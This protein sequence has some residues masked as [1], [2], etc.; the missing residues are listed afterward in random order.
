MADRKNTDTLRPEG[1][2]PRALDA[3]L[4]KLLG[5]F[6]CVEITG[7][8]WCG[9]TWT[10]L[11]HA[12]SVDR[13]DD[14]AALSAAMMDA[15]LVL[16]GKAPH[17]I[18]EW[19]EVP[20]IWDAV[21]RRVDEQGNSKGLFVL[22]GSSKP[23]SDAIRHSGTGRIARIHMRSMSLFETGDSNGSVSLSSI[24]DGD[25]EPR[26]RKT[27]MSEIARWCCRGG[28]PS[29]LGMEDDFALE[30]P[31]EY[32]KSV[33]DVSVRSLNK[34][35]VVAQKLMMALSLNLTQSVT[36][37]VLARDV[38]F[39]DE[40]AMPSVPTIEAYLDLL[41]S[42][43]LL[44]DLTGWEP[45]LISKQRVRTRP[46]RFFVDPSIPAAL[47][48]ATPATLL[49]DMQTLGKLFES[50]CIRDLRVYLSVLPGIGNQINYYLDDKGLEV[51]AVIQMGDGRWGAFEIKLSDAKIDEAAACL[52]RFAGKI[53]A[54]KAARVKAPEFLAVL[55]GKG[56]IAYKRNDGVLVIPIATLAP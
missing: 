33:L 46:K 4:E 32:I 29:I 17:L 55:I 48:G 14:P 1:Y 27:E 18:D 28:W 43:F 11:A 10:S 40:D 2:R 54:N 7:P 49:R 52:N 38:A 5:A 50:L 9:K 56:D 35:P 20:E 25:F 15:S 34:N 26:R 3:R 12:R 44:E 42:L 24:F 37:K 23:K 13:L 30:T 31:R 6:G 53:T 16:E 19:Q 36:Y 21:R 41:K 47:L 45:P 22:T 39:G 8:K 51:D